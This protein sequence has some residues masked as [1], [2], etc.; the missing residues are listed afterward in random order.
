VIKAVLASAAI[1]LIMLLGLFVDA[2]YRRFARRNPA[3]GPFRP[4]GGGCGRCACG[5]GRCSTGE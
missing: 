4:E 1:L 3:L 5:G 2:L